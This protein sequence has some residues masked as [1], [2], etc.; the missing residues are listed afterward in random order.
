MWEVLH[1][2][3]ESHYQEGVLKV[4]AEVDSN[5]V[6]RCVSWTEGSRDMHEYSANCPLECFRRNKRARLS[7]S[8][9]KLPDYQAAYEWMCGGK[10]EDDLAHIYLNE[11]G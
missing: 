5:Y 7:L 4:T 6:N 9:Q 8:D 3:L 10:T 2:H 11:R 1:T